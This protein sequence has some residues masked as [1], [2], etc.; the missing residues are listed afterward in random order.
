MKRKFALILI[1]FAGGFALNLAAAWG[2]AI[3][4]QDEWTWA[5][6]NDQSL[7]FLMSWENTRA[8]TYEGWHLNVVERFGVKRASATN[9][10]YRDTPATTLIAGKLP[11]WSGIHNLPAVSFESDTYGFIDAAYGW[12]LVSYWQVWTRTTESGTYDTSMADAWHVGQW[13]LPTHPILRGNLVNTV[14]Y[15]AVLMLLVRLPGIFRR[16]ARRA[17]GRCPGCNKPIC[18]T[19]GRLCDG[20]GHAVTWINA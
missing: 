18:S 6:A 8:E 19:D 11:A 12:P 14:F 3:S 9:G 20:C 4:I 16:Y 7:G 10:A 1:C 5:Q 17:L 15:G 2:L 13:A